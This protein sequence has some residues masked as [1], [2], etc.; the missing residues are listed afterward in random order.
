MGTS[1]SF[2]AQENGTQWFTDYNYEQNLRDFEF[3]QGH[4]SIYTP[5]LK[6]KLED[7]P[8]IPANNG[9]YA[10]DVSSGK[11]TMIPLPSE[12]PEVPTENGTY[13]FKCT[14]SAEGAT[15]GWVLDT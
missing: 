1:F 10:I 12:L 2:Y 5:N 15:Y 7:Y 14:K 8:D 11:A 13:T 3:P 6:K 9:I 4:E